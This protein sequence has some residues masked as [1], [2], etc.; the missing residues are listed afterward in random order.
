MKFDIR[1]FI[2]DVDG[3]LTNGKIHLSD[4]GE[5]FKTFSVKDGTAIKKLTKNNILTAFMTGRCSK[6]V[7]KRA[8]E[9]G[10]DLVFQSVANKFEKI[11]EISID[12]SI[13][14]KNIAFVGDDLNDLEAM[15]SVGYKFT[16]YDG[17]EDLK[18]I[19]DYISPRFGGDSVIRDIVDNYLN[20]KWGE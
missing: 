19:A 13:S 16:M 14:L 5:S 11:K 2:M 1:L 9:L 8:S 10:V 15:R 3:T 12:L 7:E 20:L 17:I 6:I 4:Y 18:K